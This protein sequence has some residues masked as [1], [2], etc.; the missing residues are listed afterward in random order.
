LVTTAIKVIALTIILFFFCFSQTSNSIIADS[1]ATTS[2]STMIVLGVAGAVTM[3]AFLIHY[4][5]DIYDEIH[6]WRENNAL[7][8]KASPVIT[9]LGDGAFSAGLFGGFVGYGL[10]FE[11]KKS[12]EVGK[13]GI[14]SF[15]L[16]GVSVQLFKYLC[17]RE[18][19]SDATRPGGFWYGPF[20]YFDKHKGGKRGLAAFD[21][22]PSGHTTTAFSAAT[23]LS[24]FYTEPW[25]SYTSYSLASLV[26]VSRVMERTH[27][28][29]DCFVGA[30][31]GHYGTRLVEKLNYNS[32]GITLLP[33][34]DEHQYGLLL[35]VKF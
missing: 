32:G 28:L 33:Q 1:L 6:S 9:N 26:G 25:V 21:S 4:D 2:S 15:L 24:D 27:W 12:F 16:T 17:G 31:I 14:E 35:S 30:I 22:F 10:I 11:D 34:A 19:P 20:A 18:R 13:I 29:S 23:T 8:R 5:Q 3:T 7:V